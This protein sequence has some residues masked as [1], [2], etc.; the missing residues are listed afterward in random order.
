MRLS[1]VVPSWNASAILAPH[2]PRMVDEAAS[3]HGGAEIVVVDDGSDEDAEALASLVKNTKR[4]TQLVRLDT[5][6]GFSAASNAGARAAGGE[7]LLFLNTDMHVEPGC[8]TALLTVLDE[9][10][11]LF[12]VSPVIVN[13][14]EGF[15]ES[16][17]VMRF[18]RGV[19]DPM[20]LGRT[21]TPAPAPGKLRKV[22]HVCGGALA[23]RRAEF[24]A[25]GGFSTLYAPFYWD[26]SDLGWRARRSGWDLAETG[27]ARVVHD[28]AQTIR[29]VGHRCVKLV[30]E[31]NRILFTWLHLAGWR[32]WTTHALWMPVRCLAAVVRR[33]QT[34]RGTLTA[35]ARLPEVL[36]HRSRLRSS[37]STARAL[38]DTVRRA[39]PGG[40]PAPSVES[41]VEEGA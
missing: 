36:R 25:L 18:H 34:A 2:L 10:P 33:D 40:W 13:A 16:T 31:R 27:T 29:R 20:A 22:S 17:L 14:E 28:H 5:H 23:C 38:L 24:L 30:Y 15:P 26:D 7:S 32:G 9:R 39:G 6:S 21:G 11:D 35:F 8:F 19:F 4:S 41:T 37:R 3:V 1:V 12:A